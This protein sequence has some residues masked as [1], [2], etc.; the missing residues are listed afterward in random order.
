MYYRQ[1]SGKFFENALLSVLPTAYV[2]THNT[3]CMVA[4]SEWRVNIMEDATTEDE[5]FLSKFCLSEEA[6]FYFCGKIKR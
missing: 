5:T 1:G 4:R 2:A 3:K 6:M